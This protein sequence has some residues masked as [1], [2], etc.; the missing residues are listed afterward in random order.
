MPLCAKCLSVNCKNKNCLIHTQQLISVGKKLINVIL[1]LMTNKQQ[2]SLE[3][4]SKLG[5][6]F[7]TEK[8]KEKLE[9]ENLGQYVVIDVEQGKYYVDSDRLVAVDK[10]TKEFGNKLFYIVQIGNV[11]HPSMNFSA[12]KYAWNF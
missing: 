11:Q 4:I 9:K 7:Y 6:K 8:L 5:E 10:A 1:Y 3:D 12:K 2:L